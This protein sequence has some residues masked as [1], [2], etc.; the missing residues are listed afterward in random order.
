[1]YNAIKHNSSTF[2][3]YIMWYM[4]A[5][6]PRYVA[7]FKSL[8]KNK[9]PLSITWLNAAQRFGMYQKPIKNQTG[10]FFLIQMVIVSFDRFRAATSENSHLPRANLCI[11]DVLF[12]TLSVIFSLPLICF[13]NNIINILTIVIILI[14]NFN[15]TEF[16]RSTSHILKPLIYSVFLSLNS[17]S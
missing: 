14:N 8:L 10:I 16:F 13:V 4:S 17:G 5:A 2:Y 12:K 6:I 11:H 15:K 1:M 9:Y 3:W 7:T